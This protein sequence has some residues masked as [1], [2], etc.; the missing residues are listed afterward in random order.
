MLYEKNKIKISKLANLARIRNHVPQK[1]LKTE[2]KQE[3]VKNDLIW[4]KKHH[5]NLK[6]NEKAGSCL[7]DQ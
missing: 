6:W 2:L 5:G 4:K 1:R 7:R 3:E